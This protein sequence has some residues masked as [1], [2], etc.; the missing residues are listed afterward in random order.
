MCPVC[1]REVETPPD[2]GILSSLLTPPDGVDA[3]EW[4]RFVCGMALFMW[5]K[6]P[7]WQATPAERINAWDAV[8]R[9]YD[10]LCG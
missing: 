10:P 3:R 8:C 1:T 2:D 5:E 4:Q 7:L 9:E 6:S